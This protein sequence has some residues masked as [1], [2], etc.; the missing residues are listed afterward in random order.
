MSSVFQGENTV[1]RFA[2][3]LRLQASVEAGYA[4]N[5]WEFGNP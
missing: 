5:I 2:G 3:A 1:E 4:V